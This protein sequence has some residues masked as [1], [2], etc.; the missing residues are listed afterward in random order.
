MIGRIRTVALGGLKVFV[1]VNIGLRIYNMMM[2]T[3]MGFDF[4]QLHWGCLRRKIQTMD[5]HPHHEGR[6]RVE[7]VTF[8]V[9]T[10][11]TV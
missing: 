8:R 10:T 11:N 7:H 5:A 9:F 4:V 2:V 6:R 1:I 3:D